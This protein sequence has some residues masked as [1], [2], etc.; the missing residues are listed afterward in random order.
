MPRIIIMGGQAETSLARSHQIHSNAQASRLALV[1][2]GKEVR[3]DEGSEG[4]EGS[5][6][7][8]ACLGITHHQP[9][10]NILCS[11]LGHDPEKAVW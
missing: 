10:V 1:T 3:Y 11:I 2:A 6:P 8:R 5:L 9:E 4:S 7:C